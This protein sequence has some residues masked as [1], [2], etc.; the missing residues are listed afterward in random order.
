MTLD[1][2]RELLALRKE[3][4]LSSL[5]DRPMSIAVDKLRRL[6]ELERIDSVERQ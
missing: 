4:E 5:G 2:K 1:E 3:M 6:I